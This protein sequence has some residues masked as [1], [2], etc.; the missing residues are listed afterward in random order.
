[1]SFQRRRF[2]Y[3]PQDQEPALTT[4]EPIRLI[5]G[6]SGAGKTSWAAHAAMGDGLFSTYIDVADL[7]SASVPAALARE[8]AAR[9]LHGDMEALRAVERVALSGVESLLASSQALATHHNTYT[10][11]IDNAHRLAIDDA[12]AISSALKGLRSVFLAQPTNELNQLSTALAVEPET[13]RG[14]GDDTIAAE[15][16]A[17]GCESSLPTVVWLKRL[18]GGTFLCTYAALFR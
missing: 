11:V 18:T 13:L 3:K 15:A 5:V 14:W 9:W 8:L 6:F 17:A 16:N 10:V 2:N 4:N 12:R 1:M 7:P